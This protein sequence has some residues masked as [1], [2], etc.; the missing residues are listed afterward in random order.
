[1]LTA[2]SR[3]GWNASALALLTLLDLARDRVRIVTPYVRL[4]ERFSAA[5]ATTVARGVQV[6]LLV[7]GPHADRRMVAAQ[8]RHEYDRLLRNGIE[9]WTYQ[10]TVLHLKL[11]T[12]DRR[13]ALVGTTNFDMRSVALNEQVS[14]LLD[15]G[16]L[17]ARLDAQLDVDLEDSRRLDL[18]SWRSRG[19]RDRMVETAADLLG[20]PLRGFGAQG[21]SGSRPW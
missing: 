7:G 5:L 1:V 11:V 20:K 14:L 21:L 12:A 8:S 4:P 17:V 15:D 3:S 13:L 9:L 18:R 10:P 19:R 16:A 6:Q 2:T